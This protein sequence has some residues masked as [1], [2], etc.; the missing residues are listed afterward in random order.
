[1]SQ[2]FRIASGGLID[3]GKEISF[4]VLNDILSGIYMKFIISKEDYLKKF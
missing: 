2:E 3:R 4:I 1:M